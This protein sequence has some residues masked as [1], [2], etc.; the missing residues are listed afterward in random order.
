[1]VVI[2]HIVESRLFNVLVGGPR[3]HREVKSDLMV[4]IGLCAASFDAC[5]RHFTSSIGEFRNDYK[6]GERLLL[7]RLMI[8]KSNGNRKHMMICDCTQF[9]KTVTPFNLESQGKW[10]PRNRRRGCLLY[11][12]PPVQLGIL[13]E[14]SKE[15]QDRPREK[16]CER[17]LENHKIDLEGI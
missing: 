4:S 10:D 13:R 16:S 5:I 6:Q 8:S 14:E 17:A 9:H 3:A 11:F 12:S 1:M 7:K 2:V 15:P